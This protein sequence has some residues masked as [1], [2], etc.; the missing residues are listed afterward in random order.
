MT[1]EQDRTVFRQP[2]PGGDRTSMRPTPGRRGS[3]A[4]LRGR[5]GPQSSD[6]Q[7]SLDRQA[8]RAAQAPIRFSTVIG[9]NPLVNSAS[10]L[11]AVFEKISK[12][13]TH[14][15]VGS[16]HRSLMHEIKRFEDNAKEVGVR[17]E[18]ALSARYLLCAALDEAVLHTPWG[19]D[20]AWGQRT[21]LSAYHSETSGGEKCFIILDRMLTAPSENLHMLELF[22]LIIS[23]GF[24]GKYRLSHN[25][26][27]QLEQLRDELF[28][29]IRSVR[30]DSERT[31]SPSWQ[32]LGRGRR[33]LANFLPM[34]VV[35]SVF[36][37]MLL[38]GYTG[39][40]AWMRWESKP[41]LNEL[42]PIAGK[43]VDNA[44]VGDTQA[45]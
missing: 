18:I 1:D 43:V 8:P 2:T 24:E 17:P 38:V 31:L 28:R 22:Y 19:G 26:R 44:D 10:T 25:G 20:S 11:I 35:A 27:D 41:V 23:L 12:S 32:G 39:F 33:T 16:L 40:S 6:S 13:M 5:A 7:D 45:Q 9:L 15:D 14:P 4:D 30:G 3:N 21:L 34:W 29:T 37:A 36:V 42:Q